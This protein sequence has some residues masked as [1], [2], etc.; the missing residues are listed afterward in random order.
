MG[1][2]RK[3]APKR[4]AKEVLTSNTPSKSAKPDINVCG[5]NG[6]VRLELFHYLSYVQL[7]KCRR[8]SHQWK[9]TV[10][11]NA[12]RLA[13]EPES[14]GFSFQVEKR[15]FAL[16][17]SRIE[18][19]SRFCEHACLQDLKE[20]SNLLNLARQHWLGKPILG[21]NFRS[22][23][24]SIE[25]QDFDR[26]LV[27]ECENKVTEENL[28]HLLH[29]FQHAGKTKFENVRIKEHIKLE[30][31]K[32]LPDLRI[33]VSGTCL[34]EVPLKVHNFRANLLS[35]VKRHVKAGKL[36]WFAEEDGFEDVIQDDEAKPPAWLFRKG[37]DAKVNDQM[38]DVLLK[39]AEFVVGRT[40]HIT[41]YKLSVKFIRA[42]L[43]KFHM[44]RDTSKV[45]TAVS[46]NLFESQW[47]DLTTLKEGRQ[48]IKTDY[49]Y[50]ETESD[51]EEFEE[52]ESWKYRYRYEANSNADDEGC[53]YYLFRSKNTGEVLKLRVQHNYDYIGW[54]GLD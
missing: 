19:P 8:V 35:F 6:D 50:K 23:H 43:K 46:F 31:H 45:M 24:L 51:D 29:F 28:L 41:R 53:E 34:V 12:D 30:V 33:S 52:P 7:Q 38:L 9:S 13:R 47:P 26:S 36:N 16:E 48:G 25:S 18:L 3:R 44:L 14:D 11:E 42:F 20:D 37:R 40:C 21:A 32:V 39:G 2:S 49:D 15:D 4:A 27:L 1:K 22:V 54:M 10:D 17:E 5:L